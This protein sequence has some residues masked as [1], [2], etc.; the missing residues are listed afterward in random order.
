MPSSKVTEA[1]DRVD[2]LLASARS[3]E[4]ESEWDIDTARHEIEELKAAV[5]R[6]P[7][8]TPVQVVFA[9]PTPK[10]DSDPPATSGVAVTWKKGVRLGKL[11]PWAVVVL[12]LGV[13]LI[14]AGAY[15][16]TH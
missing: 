4:P 3:R 16:L 5:A 13:A 14:A 2:R 11:P 7:M 1:L 6:P 9:Q 10:P 15:V 12:G 8:P